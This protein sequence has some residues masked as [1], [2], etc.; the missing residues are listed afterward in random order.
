M[1]PQRRLWAGTAV[2]VVVATLVL[3]SEVFEGRDTGVEDRRSSPG[4]TAS[5]PPTRLLGVLRRA[6]AQSDSLPRSPTSDELNRVNGVPGEDFREA[7][8]VDIAGAAGPIYVW[9]ARAHAC[10][11]HRGAAGC[12]QTDLLASETASVTTSTGDTVGRG[13]T[14][15]SGLATDGVGQIRILLRTGRSATARVIENVFLVDLA[16]PPVR[17][18]WMDGRGVLHRTPL[19]APQ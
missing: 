2:V 7:R 17:A 13:V 14:R 9:P 19:E 3:G 8:R 12:V 4:Q 10:F 6:R 5:P 15:V 16:V 11:S 1:R 18:E